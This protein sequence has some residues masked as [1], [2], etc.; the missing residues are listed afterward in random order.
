MTVSRVSDAARVL[1]LVLFLLLVCG[2]ALQPGPRSRDALAGRG[3]ALPPAAAS[4][5]VP[6]AL[7]S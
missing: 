3:S 7:P 2:R 1:V 6:P 4:P 5:T